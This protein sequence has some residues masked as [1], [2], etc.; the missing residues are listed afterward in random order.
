MGAPYGYNGYLRGAPVGPREAVKQALRNTFT[1]RGRAS[2]SALWW[3]VGFAV[4]VGFVLRM[5]AGS[6]AGPTA[7]FH[8][9]SAAAVIADAVFLV[10]A[11]PVVLAYLALAVRRLHDSDMSGWWLVPLAI[12][13]IVGSIALLVF[14]VIKGSPGPNRFG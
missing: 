13:P 3:F 8:S 9:A 4:A 12:I 7:L 6:I 2:R 1:Y 10:V 5:A 11:V 14:Y